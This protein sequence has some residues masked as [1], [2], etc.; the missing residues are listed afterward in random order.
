ML[1]S[2]AASAGGQIEKAKQIKIAVAA[3]MRV[4]HKPRRHPLK[5][6]QNWSYVT[7]AA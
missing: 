6:G 4:M 2:P 7:A 5:K 3:N 1:R